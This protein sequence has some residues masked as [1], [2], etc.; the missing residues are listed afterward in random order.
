MCVLWSLCLVSICIFCVL[1]FWCVC[2][3]VS[4]SSLCSRSLSLSLYGAIAIGVSR[5]WW[6]LETWPLR[7]CVE[8]FW[9][10][11]GTPVEGQ[12]EAGLGKGPRNDNTSSRRV[13]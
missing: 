12:E 6:G 7:L 11:G 8:P 2:L 9:G 4:L 13:I 3:F 10:L 5:A 1:L